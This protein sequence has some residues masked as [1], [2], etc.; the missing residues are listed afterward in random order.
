MKRFLFARH[1]NLF[2]IMCLCA[3]PA[4]VDAYGLWVSL[5]VVCVYSLLSVLGERG[6]RADTTEGGD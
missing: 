6:L 2:D 3:V 5:G 1:F 4:F